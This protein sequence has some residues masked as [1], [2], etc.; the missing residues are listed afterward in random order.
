MRRAIFNLLAIFSL[1][2]LLVVA[3][4]WVQSYF[5]NT[6]IGEG[7]SRIAVFSIDGHMYV[8][9]GTTFNATWKAWSIWKLRPFGQDIAT[10]MK[11]Y[12]I[13]RNQIGFG[14]L[15]GN[16]G[17][18]IVCILL[19]YWFPALL[20]SIMPSIWIYKRWRGRYKAGICQHCGY[21]LKGSVGKEACPECGEQIE[22]SYA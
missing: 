10:D 6:A 13:G 21:N 9:F 14:Y 4:L 11:R 1:L 3:G 12:F 2:M 8:W 15:W 16:G 17:Q 5:N 20:L 18:Q 7:K 19:P 22:R